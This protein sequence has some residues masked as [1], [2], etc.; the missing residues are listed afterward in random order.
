MRRDISPSNRGC[1][2]Q[3][4][5]QGDSSR[6]KRRRARL[7]AVA[8]CNSSE[9][10]VLVLRGTKSSSISSNGSPLTRRA[11][12]ANLMRQRATGTLGGGGFFVATLAGVEELLRYTSD[13]KNGMRILPTSTTRSY[14]G[15]MPPIDDE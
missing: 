3:D 8:P 14:A 12:L 9:P 1:S 6:G 15:S 2:S 4:G 7:A 10:M 11:R 5:R 13:F